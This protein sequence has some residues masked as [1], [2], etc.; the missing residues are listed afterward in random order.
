VSGNKEK[1]L[2]SKDELEKF[3][4]GIINTKGTN[5][6]HVHLGVSAWE[7]IQKLADKS[8]DFEPLLKGLYEI[9]KL[10]HMCYKNQHIDTD[11]VLDNVEDISRE[12]QDIVEGMM[13]ERNER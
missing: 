11:K 4:C 7:L 2:V 6:K 9:E 13:G 3:V 1:Y 10:T 12:L 8:V 5:E